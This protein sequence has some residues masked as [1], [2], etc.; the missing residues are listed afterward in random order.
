MKR[1]SIVLA[2]LFFSS[3]AFAYPMNASNTEIVDALNY[4]KSRQD[5]DGCIGGFAASAWVISGIVAAGENPSSAGWSSGSKSLVD[6]IKKDSSWFNDS[7]RNATDFERQIIAIVAAGEDPTNFNELDYVAKLKSMHDGTLMGDASYI[8]DD[9]W[10]V[11][12]LI[13][14][15]E[16]SSSTEIQ[17]ML[18]FIES[19]QGADNG[20]SWAVG[21]SSDADS[22]ADAVMALI[23]GGKDPSSTNIQNAMDYLKTQ[24]DSNNAGFM[25]WGTANPDSTSHSIDAVVSVGGNPTDVAWQENGT[26]PLEYL[27]DW[28]QADGGFSNPYADPPLTSSEWTTANA[29]NALLGE[30]YPVEIMETLSMRIRIEGPTETIMDKEIV[31]PDSIEFISIGGSSYT[32]AEPSLLMGLLEAGTENGFSVSVSDEWYPSMGFYVTEIAEEGAEGMNGWNYRVDYHTTGFHSADSFIWQES[33]PP[34]PSHSEV[35][36]FYGSW[37]SNALM[38]TAE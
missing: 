28:Q 1:I 16:P 27:L 36:W 33:S 29:L 35:V 11:I 32:L 9:V 10:G 31:L 4:L 26:N 15:G 5:S 7:S 17:G 12:A 22:A 18:S 14:A 2:L 13:A 6:C 24:Q 19:N 3:V 20:W 30:P 37:D 8:N 34:T 25:S 23:A 38:I 21:Q